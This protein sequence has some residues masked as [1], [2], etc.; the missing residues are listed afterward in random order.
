LHG[1]RSR[2][3]LLETR[4]FPQNPEKSL[5]LTGYSCKR[6]VARGSGAAAS[7]K[8]D[9][10]K[11]ELFMSGTSRVDSTPDFLRTAIEYRDRLKAE[12]AKV[13][14]FLSEADK[15]QGDRQAGKPKADFPEFLLTGNDEVL[16]ALNPLGVKSETVH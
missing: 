6:R 2:R 12:L 3:P 16:E 9:A 4:G 10:C 1:A 7:V 13:D 11:M 15:R 5:C 8:R 14:A